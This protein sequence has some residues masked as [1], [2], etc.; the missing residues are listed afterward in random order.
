MD[1]EFIIG[2]FKS[3]EILCLTLMELVEISPK[4]LRPD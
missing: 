1:K 3:N 2:I 4:Y